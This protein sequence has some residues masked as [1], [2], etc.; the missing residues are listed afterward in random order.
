VYK[1]GFFV[2]LSLNLSISHIKITNVYKLY[3]KIKI[4]KIIIYNK[5]MNLFINTISKT[6]SI[7][8]F[9]EKREIIDQIDFEI[10]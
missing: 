5:K 10:K 3:K 6:S 2:I 4:R 8:L 9:N 1:L 7:I